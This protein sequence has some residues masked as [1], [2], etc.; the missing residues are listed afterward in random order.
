[1]FDMVNE[2][3]SPLYWDLRHQ[4]DDWPR[5]SSWA[6][7]IAFE[8]ILQKADVIIFCCGQGMEAIQLLNHRPDINYILALDISNAAIIKA[9]LNLY[10]S[11]V[12]K[13]KIDFR[14]L[15]VFDL[16]SLEPDRF[17][18]GISIQNFEHWKPERHPEAIK[19]MFRVLKPKGK[20]FITG[21][22]R[23]WDLTIKN[24][25]L[26]VYQGKEYNLPNDLHYNNWSEQDFYDLF[27]AV[28]ATEV[29][30]FRKR[31]KD[32]VIAEGKKS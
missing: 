30:F 12:D 11:E 21:V 23:S 28:K 29:T 24:Y 18:Y 16:S 7:T 1:M 14:T 13:S 22:G 2:V 17:D 25:G 32:R 15:D 6:M 5:W 8:R 27:M 20:L 9:N 26:I 4:R 19:Q 10:E 31:G 3:N